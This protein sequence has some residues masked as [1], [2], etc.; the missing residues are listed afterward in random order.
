MAKLVKDQM[1]EDEIAKDE[2]GE[3]EVA[4]YRKDKSEKSGSETSEMREKQ[5]LGP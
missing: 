4:W 2:M 1:L 3:D 5:I